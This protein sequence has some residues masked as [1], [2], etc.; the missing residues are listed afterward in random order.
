MQARVVVGL[1][2]GVDSAVAAWLLKEQGY[3][4]IGVFMRNWEETAPDGRCTADQDFADVRAVCECIGIPYYGVNF[5]K[6]YKERVFASFLEELQ[7]GRTPNP[8]VLCNTQIKFAAFL[9]FAMQAGAEKLA[10]GHF[11]RLRQGADG[12]YQLLCGVD[13]GKDQTY[14]LHGLGQK[15]LSRAMF[16]VG[17]MTK[18][19]VRQ[20]AREIGLPVA[21]KKDSTGICFIG[22]RHFK[23]FLQQYL[24]TQPGDIISTTG[25]V[26]G[27]HDGLAFYT[28]GQRRGLGIGGRGDGRRWFVVQKDLAGNRLIVHQGEDAPQ[29]YATALASEKLHFIAGQAP[30]EQFDCRARIRHRQAFQDCR[31]TM[32]PDG[33][34]R[35]DFAQRQRAITP[36]QSVVLYQGDVCLGGGIIASPIQSEGDML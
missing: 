28:L 11:A 2:G 24:P 20:K 19:Q 26:V 17:G 32:L 6:Q 4:V 13:P 14:F 33:S 10:T 34:A 12:G 29:L 3:D 22:E 15:E 35:V 25:E 21:E 16:P 8:D 1:S 23:Q 27:R 31:V 5:S 9:D 18:A 30:A 7:K 36:G